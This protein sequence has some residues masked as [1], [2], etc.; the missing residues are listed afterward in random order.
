MPLRRKEPAPQDVY[1]AALK[2]LSYRP[3]SEQEL[4]RRL[5]RRYPHPPAMVDNALARL[6]DR[7]LLDDA[8]FS[9][10][11]R[12]SRERHRPRGAAVIRW[13]L[14]RMGVQRE[15]AEESL[16]GMDEGENALRA[17][18]GLERRLSKT[19]YNAFR[20]KLVAHLRRRGFRS[21]VVSSTVKLLWEELADP[22]D[23]EVGGQG[24]EY[25]HKDP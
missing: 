6:K 11:W 19:D 18:R 5:S 14:L 2:L 24:P 17:A 22:G 4:R 9:Q 21:G 8:A 3:H 23:G 16:L 7:G 12:E 15:V 20:T 25:Q 1:D 13:E 10:F